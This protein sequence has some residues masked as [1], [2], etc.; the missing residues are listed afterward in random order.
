VVV[1]EKEV[2]EKE[3][4]AAAAAAAAAGSQKGNAWRPP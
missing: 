1:G 3:K 2:G 4:V